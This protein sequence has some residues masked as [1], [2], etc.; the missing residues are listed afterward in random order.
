MSLMTTKV[1]RPTEPREMI[2]PE[3]DVVNVDGTPENALP[4][5]CYAEEAEVEEEVE[6]EGLMN[7][8]KNIFA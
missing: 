6:K 5:D 4:E 2:H 1:D 7:K 3:L 8:V